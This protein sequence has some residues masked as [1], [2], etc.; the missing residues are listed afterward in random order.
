MIE[1]NVRLPNGTLADRHRVWYL[2]HDADALVTT[3]HVMHCA[4]DV[5]V[6]SIAYERDLD[7]GMTFAQAE[8]WVAALPEMAEVSDERDQLIAEMADILTDEQAERVPRAYPPWAVGVA[9]E[10]GQRVR[11]DGK[12]FRCVQAHNSQDGREPTGA[13]ALWARTA[14]DGEVPEWA[15]PTGAHDAYAIGDK[16]THA[17]K[18]WESTYDG[19]NV[20]EPGVYGWSEVS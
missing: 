8:T 1:R 7:V 6:T 3:V 5:E 14:Q 15:Q 17:G 18:V 9:Y 10:I 2:C 13:P 11:Y 19:A 16:V 4:G 20:W 12:L